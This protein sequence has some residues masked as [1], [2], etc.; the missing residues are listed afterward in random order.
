MMLAV[1]YAVA[2]DIAAPAAMR[3]AVPEADPAV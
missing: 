3:I 1:L 2:P